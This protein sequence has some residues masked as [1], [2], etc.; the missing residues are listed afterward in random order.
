MFGG[1]GLN[2]YA[3]PVRVFFMGHDDTF[4]TRGFE[5]GKG[6]SCGA[7]RV[8][9]PNASGYKFHT[10]GAFKNL[11]VARTAGAGEN[12]SPA[13]FGTPRARDA[14]RPTD[15]IRHTRSDRI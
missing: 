2:F 8:R 6:G 12:F 7:A 13:V 4:S 3:G 14:T 15:T 5:K 10:S 11:L 9:T 1:V